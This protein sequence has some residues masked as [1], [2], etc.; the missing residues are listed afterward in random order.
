[1]ITKWLNVLSVK[2]MFNH[3]GNHVTMESEQPV[4]R[5]EQIG[6]SL[7]ILMKLNFILFESKLVNFGWIC[8]ENDRN[9]Q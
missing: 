7:D 2:T 1:M 9:D 6:M 8:M 3:T 5:V 4:M